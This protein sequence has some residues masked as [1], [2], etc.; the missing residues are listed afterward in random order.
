MVSQIEQRLPGFRKGDEVTFRARTTLE[1]GRAR[2]FIKTM[3]VL[4]AAMD[5]KSAHWKYRLGPSS[6]D[7]GT[8]GEWKREWELEAA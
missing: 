7:A 8:E 3:V 5:E 4:E 2:F 1:D 6:E